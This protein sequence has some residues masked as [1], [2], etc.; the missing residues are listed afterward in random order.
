MLSQASLDQAASRY[1]RLVLAMGAHDADYVDA[2]YGPPA[3]KDEVAAEKLT[4]EQI[5]DSAKRLVEMLPASQ[6]A[7]A[8][9]GRDDAT[10]A[11]LRRHYLRRQLEA[12]ATR[13]EMLLGA[14]LTFDEQAVALYD[15][16]PPRHTEA[17]FAAILA[18][19]DPKLPGEGPITERLEAFRNQFVI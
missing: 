8:R 19:L 18:T 3:W 7:V 11:E 2:Y 6:V 14:R 4:L 15:A 17:E 12:L 5:R 16:A 9:T 1:V 10:L 13:A